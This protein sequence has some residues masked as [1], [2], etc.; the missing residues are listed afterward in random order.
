MFFNKQLFLEFASDDAIRLMPA[1]KL[2][3]LD[4][5]EVFDDEIIYQQDGEECMFKVLPEWCDQMKQ[6]SLF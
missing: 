1:T 3:L 6:D 2:R 4:G 5:R